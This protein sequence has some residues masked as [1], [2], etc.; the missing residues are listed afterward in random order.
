MQEQLESLKR[1]IA[2]GTKRRSLG[3]FSWK[4]SQTTEIFPPKKIALLETNSKV[5]P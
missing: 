5:A 1:D 4:T 3:F 2:N